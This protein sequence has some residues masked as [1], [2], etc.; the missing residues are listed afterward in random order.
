[1]SNLSELP[2]RTRPPFLFSAALGNLRLL[3]AF[4]ADVLG[5]VFS[6][7]SHFTLVTH[8]FPFGM[9]LHSMLL[10]IYLFLASPI[11][12][13]KN[14]LTSLLT[15]VLAFLASLSFEKS[16]HLQEMLL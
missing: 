12:K 15:S 5:Y 7:D 1:M 11:W 9:I 10:T 14:V 16:G 13:S 3:L 4:F 2:A 8:I 6:L